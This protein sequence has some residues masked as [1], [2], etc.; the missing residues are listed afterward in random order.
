MSSTP[1]SLLTSPREL[2]IVTRADANVTVKDRTVTSPNFDVSSINKLL[3]SEEDLLLSPLFGLSEERL[4][5]QARVREEETGITPADLTVY[6]RLYAPDDRLEELADRMIA[7]ETVVGAFI[8]PGVAPAMWFELEPDLAAPVMTTPN[9]LNLQG[10]LNSANEGGI[11]ARFAWDQPGGKGAGINVIDV[12]GAWSFEH[13]DL[14]ANQ[15]GLVAGRALPQRRWRNHGTAVLGMISAD[16]N[17]RG[18]TG[19]CPEANVSGVSVFELQTVKGWGTAAAITQAAM[20]LNRGDILLLEL[21]RSG[22]AVNFKDQPEQVGC[23]PI[24][25]WPDDLQAIKFATKERGVVVVTAGGNGR[26]DLNSQIYDQRPPQFPVEWSN[27]FRRSTNDSGSIIVGAGGPP[28]SAS[29]LQRLQF[30]N[31][32]S[33]NEQESIFDAQGWG[34]DVTTTGFGNLQN[35]GGPDENFWY[36]GRFSGTSS[37]APMIAGAL[38]CLQGIQEARSRPRLTPSEARTRL[39]TTG[40]PQLPDPPVERIGRRP[41]LRELFESL[42]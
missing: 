22:P 16:E 38:A 25:W 20:K 14:K 1:T 30:S 6:K 17:G 40:R 4:A 12:E 26:Q 10:Y 27:P 13:D 2:V 19:I 28:T 33:G 18:I 37:A 3:E 42:P 11:D 15:G 39:R 9:F 34:Q 41:D 31:F 35:G 36:T 5:L 23:I 8:K 7:E 24:E 21:Q 29:N 32:H